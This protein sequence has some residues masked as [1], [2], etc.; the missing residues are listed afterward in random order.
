MQRASGYLRRGIFRQ[1][2]Q[3]EPG[4]WRESTPLTVGVLQGR[5]SGAR[6]GQQRPAEVARAVK[7]EPAGAGRW[8]RARAVRDSSAGN[9][10][11]F[12]GAEQEPDL[13][14]ALQEKLQIGNTVTDM[15]NSFKG[16]ISRHSQKKSV[17]H[18]DY[19]NKNVPN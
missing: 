6:G 14:C 12:Q 4:L 16:L 1:G 7:G 18:K 5:L 8:A 11:A 2:R 17:S 10:E 9:G 13:V 19:V 15:R 3:L